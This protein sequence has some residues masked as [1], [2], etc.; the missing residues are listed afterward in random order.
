MLAFYY[1]LRDK[2]FSTSFGYGDCFKYYLISI[3]YV[4]ALLWFTHF[5]LIIDKTSEHDTSSD[6]C[7][8]SAIMIKHKSFITFITNVGLLFLLLF[9]VLMASKNKVSI[10]IATV[11]NVL[12]MGSVIIM[13][14]FASNPFNYALG[15]PVVWFYVAFLI[16]ILSMVYLKYTSLYNTES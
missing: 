10:G 16:F 14:G 8:I 7:L 1:T 6:F 2:F 3:A 12:A 9:D 11:V 5:D 13:F 4:A 15:S